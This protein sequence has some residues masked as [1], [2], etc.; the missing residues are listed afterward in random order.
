[1]C[2][3]KFSMNSVPYKRKYWR[4]E[5]M[6]LMQNHFW[7]YFNWADCSLQHMK[8][9]IYNIGGTL[10]LVLW[11]SFAKS[12]NWSKV[13]AKILRI[14][15]CYKI[16]IHEVTLITISHFDVNLLNSFNLQFLCCTEFPIDLARNQV[17]LE[18][19]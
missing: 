19:S 11:I 18:V 8:L 5:I 17:R 4:V 7:R 10:N 12:P 15:Y 14:Q 9:F 2:T 3:I 6:H 16:E 13:I 1:M